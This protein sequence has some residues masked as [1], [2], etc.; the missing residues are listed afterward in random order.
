MGLRRE[1]PTIFPRMSASWTA[2]P[3]SGSQLFG[4]DGARRDSVLISGFSNQLEEIDS[5]GDP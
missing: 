4:G 1:E 5:H 3:A 2:H